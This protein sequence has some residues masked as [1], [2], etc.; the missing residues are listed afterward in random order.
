M[1]MEKKKGEVITYYAFKGGTGRSMALANAA[2]LAAR[3]V[4]GKVLMI[5][6][7]LEAPG[8][9]AYFKDYMPESWAAQQ[10]ILELVEAAQ[11][12]LGHIEYGKEDIDVLFD[13]FDKKLLASCLLV[14]VPNT[15]SNLYLLKAGL[16]GPDYSQKVN[17]LDW[18][19]FYRQ[20][21]GFFPCFSLYL[22]E[23][24]DL[25]F[26]DSRTGHTD[27]GGI[28]TMSMPEKLVL[29]F[30]PNAQSLEGAI[31]VAQKATDYRKK[32]DDLMR[33]LMVYPLVS[34]LD[35][36]GVAAEQQKI[37]RARYE[38]DWQTAIQSIYDLPPTIRLTNYFDSIYVR[39]DANY[40]FG[41]SIAV[42]DDTDTGIAES[43]S[44]DYERFDRALFGAEI[45]EDFPFSGM[46]APFEINF[47]FASKDY[48]KVDH[49]TTHLSALK[50]Q[51]VI[52]WETQLLPFED[53]SPTLKRKVAEGRTD[54]TLVFLSKSLY[55]LELTPEEKKSIE[56]DWKTVVKQAIQVESSGQNIRVMP[57]LLEAIDTNGLFESA[58]ILPAK[59][60]PVAADRSPH[61]DEA[62]AKVSQKLRR[63][64][65]RL[66]EKIQR[67]KNG[68]K[69]RAHE[70]A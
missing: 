32:Y 67:E 70:P 11:A 18:A 60:Q 28:C 53:W 42:V 34:R 44:N 36:S 13:F 5:D 3:R 50:R 26:I 8:L 9:S 48:E 45:W 69:K 66:N 19:G 22:S 10:G 30:T 20:I 49:F 2:V 35:F 63:E 31:E 40:A 27:I 39:H 15:N 25:T 47:V 38:A 54:V 46:E 62:W 12:T 7:D 65:I 51:K 68:R 56:M 14:D 61:Q 16:Q 29:V 24:Y 6:W 4:K 58:A 33:P 23:N 52:E 41:E 55:D 21:P 17:N 1:E 59:N 43:L 37:W 57:I 64:I